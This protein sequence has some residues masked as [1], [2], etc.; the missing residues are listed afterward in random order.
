MVP[1]L[2]PETYQNVF[3]NLDSDKKA[4]ASV[5]L[6]N[7]AW[8]EIAIPILWQNPLMP[9]PSFFLNANNG[10]IP[11]DTPIIEAYITC[12]P[13]EAKNK[14]I[15]AGLE[16]WFPIKKRPAFNYA[17]YLQTL[18]YRLLQDAVNEVFPDTISEETRKTHV[19]LVLEELCKLFI[20]QCA[21]LKSIQ[22]VG[23]PSLSPFIIAIPSR[24]IEPIFIDLCELPGAEACLSKLQT[25][26][27]GGNIPVDLLHAFSRVVKELDSLT[28]TSLG[29]DNEGLIALIEAQTRL[30]NVKIQAHENIP[31]I[32]SAIQSK[33]E[34]IKKVSIIGR[35]SILLDDFC[36]FTNLEEL[37]LELLEFPYNRL[38]RHSLWVT[39]AEKQEILRRQREF[40]QS[41]HQA[42]IQYQLQPI[43]STSQ[44]QNQNTSQ[45][46]DLSTSIFQDISSQ[47]Q[48]QPTTSTS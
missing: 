45:T 17:S 20:S 13:E 4:L 37:T 8:C 19:T 48:N 41:F 1:Q 27:Y 9:F 30:Q 39:Q 18:N 2:P 26:E 33:T 14:L 10:N 40:Q 24:S 6:V 28:I 25:F 16:S 21:N 15:E 31:N 7:R 42:Q 38:S 32:I 12:L 46:Q 43:P 29:D 47:V 34:T 22:Y 44:I 11:S 5:I 36:G 3:R 23:Y 35:T